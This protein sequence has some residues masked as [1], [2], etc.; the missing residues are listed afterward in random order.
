MGSGSKQVALVVPA[1]GSGTRMGEEIPKPYLTIAG[2]TILEHT[3]LQFRQVDAIHELIVSTSEF[4]KDQ[5]CEIVASVFGDIELTVIEGGAERQESVFK[6]LQYVSDSAE[7]IAIHDAVRPFV[8]KQLILECINEASNPGVDGSI[9]ATPA[10]DTIKE[11]EDAKYV[12]ETPKRE[13]MWQAQTP[14]IF[15]REV[16]LRAYNNATMRKLMG[17]DDSS[18]VEMIG[19]KVSVIKSTTDNFKITYPLDFQLAKLILSGK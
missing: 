19:G 6:A 3:L 9:L 18:L 2:K 1:A 16:L 5:T 7:L 15:K 14:Q 8:S 17:T 10:K 12:V 13:R 11:V 4:F